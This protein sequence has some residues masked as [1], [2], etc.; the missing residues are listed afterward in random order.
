MDVVV[1]E[2]LSHAQLFA[3]LWIASC[4]VS[5]SFII[6]QN[7][8]KFMF[9]ERYPNTIV[10]RYHWKHSKWRARFLKVT[11][12]IILKNMF[13]VTRFI[14][15]HFGNQILNVPLN[16]FSSVLQRVAKQK[17]L[18]TTVLV[19]FSPCNLIFH[20]TVTHS[21]FNLLLCDLIAGLQG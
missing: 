15:M 21:V 11:I 4:Q 17:D 16:M 20:D 12:Y 8:F 1:V 14:M 18:K 3:I 13:F 10:C 6:S 5:L 9:I 19:F 7:L 2:L